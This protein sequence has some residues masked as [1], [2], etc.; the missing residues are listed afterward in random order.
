MHIFIDYNFNKYKLSY[1]SNLI[2]ALNSSYSDIN[3][4][5][6]DS[7][8][9]ILIHPLL[10]VSFSLSHMHFPIYLCSYHYFTPFVS[11]QFMYFHLDST[12]LDLA[13]IANLRCVVF[14]FLIDLVTLIVVIFMFDLILDI[15]SSG[16]YLLIGDL[17]LF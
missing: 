10:P 15:L 8:F 2:F 7:I 5:I 11:V 13:F 9:L 16:F 12:I 3:I 1:F 4:A 17:E 6:P 14:F